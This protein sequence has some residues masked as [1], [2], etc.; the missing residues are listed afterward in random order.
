MVFFTVYTPTM[1]P[2]RDVPTETGNIPAEQTDDDDDA[3]GL[4][5]R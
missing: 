1:E 3:G 4:P 5:Q 2:V